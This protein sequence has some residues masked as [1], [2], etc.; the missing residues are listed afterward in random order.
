MVYCIVL[1]YINSSC[2]QWFDIVG[3]VAGRASGL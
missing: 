3:W 1:H 2:L